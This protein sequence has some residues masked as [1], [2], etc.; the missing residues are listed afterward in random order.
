MMMYLYDVLTTVVGGFE[1]ACLLEVFVAL[2]VLLV[3]D[4]GPVLIPIFALHSLIAPYFIL[5]L[6]LALLSCLP[7]D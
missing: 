7:K 3:S 4:S 6:S 2:L 1:L 5:H